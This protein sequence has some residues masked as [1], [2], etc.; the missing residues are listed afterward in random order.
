[1]YESREGVQAVK[2]PEWPVLGLY[3]QFA[4][5]RRVGEGTNGGRVGGAKARKAPDRKRVGHARARKAPDQRAG[6]PLRNLPFGRG[7]SSVLA[8]APDRKRVGR[9]RAR[10]APDQKAGRPLRNLPIGR[11]P[12][13]VLW[14]DHET[15]ERGALPGE[16]ACQPA[17]I[18]TTTPSMKGGRC[19]GLAS[20][21]RRSRKSPAGCRRYNA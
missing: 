10:K 7:L 13:P 11:G 17:G 19:T 12:S 20:A 6:R 16:G 4:L 2:I 8:A 5:R 9:A 18:T 14:A 15:G 21:E 3:F 1:M